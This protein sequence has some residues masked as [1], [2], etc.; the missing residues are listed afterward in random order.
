VTA[1]ERVVWEI[2]VVTALVTVGIIAVSALAASAV[3]LID[4]HFFHRRPRS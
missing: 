1:V 4:D 3:S 2:L